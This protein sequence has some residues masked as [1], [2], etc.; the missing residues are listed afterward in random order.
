MHDG[1]RILQYSKSRAFLWRWV[2]A[3]ASSLAWASFCYTPCRSMTV[4]LLPL[5]QIDTRTVRRE[6]VLFRISLPGLIR[7]SVG[8]PSQSAFAGRPALFPGDLLREGAFS[9]CSYVSNPSPARSF[10]A[11]Q[12]L[13][14]SQA[15][16]ACGP[17]HRPPPQA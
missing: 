9:W 1:E 7:L 12:P 3:V 13:N 6:L 5:F 14:E 2:L 8:R 16:G 15:D 4:G 10:L 11:K 17:S